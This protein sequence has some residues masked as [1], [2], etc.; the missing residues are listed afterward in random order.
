[1]NGSGFRV[2]SVLGV[3]SSLSTTRLWGLMTLQP[4]RA[5]AL[6]LKLGSN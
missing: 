3:C 6:T 2:C 4:V 1:M 5:M